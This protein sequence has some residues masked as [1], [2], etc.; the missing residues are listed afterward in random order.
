MYC[1]QCCSTCKSLY[2]SL[3]WNVTM[4]TNVKASFLFS[5]YFRNLL[6]KTKGS[7]IN[8]SSVHA[9]NTSE[10]IS[11]YAASKGCLSALTNLW[12]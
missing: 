3:D 11:L 10:N 4:D 12:R 8:I 5:K 2:E 6:I 9:T 7:I 1:K